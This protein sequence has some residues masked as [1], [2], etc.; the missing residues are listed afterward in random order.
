MR[1][2]SASPS[3]CDIDIK[4]N[5]SFTNI[6]LACV[7]IMSVVAEVGPLGKKMLDFSDI[8]SFQQREM[9]KGMSWTIPDRRRITNFCEKA[10]FEK[11]WDITLKIEEYR[12]RKENLSSEYIWSQ[13]LPGSSPTPPSQSSMQPSTYPT[14]HHSSFPTVDPSIAPSIDNCR[15][16]THTSFLS[17]GKNNLVFF[18]HPFLSHHH[19]HNTIC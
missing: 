12:G 19:S 6:G 9:C 17:G 1:N 10:L 18:S 13:N 14:A 11:S 5:Y 4:L 16:C 3:R 2:S 8:Y 15:T 7:D